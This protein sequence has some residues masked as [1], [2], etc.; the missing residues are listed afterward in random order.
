MIRRL[1]NWMRKPEPVNVIEPVRPRVVPDPK[2]TAGLE[3]RRAALS[4]QPQ[5][6]FH[7]STFV[8]KAQ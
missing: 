8:R 6:A 7:S 4:Y 2:W 3:R 5:T 1:L